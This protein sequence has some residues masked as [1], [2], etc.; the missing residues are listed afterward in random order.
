MKRLFAFLRR[1][2]RDIRQDVDEELRFHID[3]RTEELVAGGMGRADARRQAAREF[4]DVD[5]ARRYMRRMDWRTERDRRRRDY[6]GEFRQDV[7]YAL[8]QLRAAP[9]F[10]LTAI[11][12]LALGIG[13][14]TAIFSV[15]S[16]VLLRPLPFPDPDR[17]YA[18]W[19]ANRTANALQA[20][21]SPVDLDDWR[22]QRQQIEDLGGY[23][24]SE[25]STGIDMTGRGQPRR[26]TV[27]F[28]TPGFSRRSAPGRRRD[29]CRV[30]TS[31]FA[32]APTRSSCCPTDSG[33]GSSAAPQALPGR[34]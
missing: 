3:A 31:S 14:N 12:T 26:L 22:A 9:V 18:V 15:V 7:R 27:V 1:S 8:R 20:P 32:A 33:S 30:K 17:L 28:V 24:Y 5:D 13:A 23:F 29:G 4:G 25:G 34:R 2:P 19:S 6:M 10:A 11:V 21:V 16:A